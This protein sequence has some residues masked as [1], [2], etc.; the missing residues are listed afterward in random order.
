M[1]GLMVCCKR[2]IYGFAALAVFAMVPAVAFA[3]T[4]ARDVTGMG[5]DERIGGRIPSE[6][7]FTDRSGDK[8]KLTEFFEDGKPVVMSLVYYNCPRLC[9][10]VLEGVVEAVGDLDALSLGVDYKVVSVSINPV[11][12]PEDATRKSEG[13]LRALGGKGSPDGWSFLTGGEQNIAALAESVGFRY[14]ADGDEFAHPASIM[15]L[16]PEGEISRYLYGIEFPAKDF[17]LA[18]LEASKGEVGPSR[19]VNK[20]LLF[21]YKF[22]PVGGKYALHALNILKGGGVITL[23]FVGL[24][25]TYL[26]IIERKR[27]N[28]GSD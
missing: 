27:T 6:L 2:L 11:E 5:V 20:V 10:F 28:G 9:S 26:I 17:R 24:L 23:L 15:F 8:V 14:L 13:V 7:E 16:T 19:I 12:T 21:C 25:I 18:L 4:D 22:D 1:T 3:I